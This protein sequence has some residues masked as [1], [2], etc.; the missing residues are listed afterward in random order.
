MGA[1]HAN[2]QQRQVTAH[3]QATCQRHLAKANA[4]LADCRLATAPRQPAM[5]RAEQIRPS[6]NV[7]R[8]AQRLL[9]N[10][11]CLVDHR[12]LLVGIFLF[13]RRGCSR[14]KGLGQACQARFILL[15]RKAA[16]RRQ[17]DQC[18][19]ALCKGHQQ[20]RS[21]A[22]ISTS[23]RSRATSTSTSTRTSSSRT[24]PVSICPGATA[25]GGPCTSFLAE[26]GLGQ[27][28]ARPCTRVER[29][30]NTG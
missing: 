24:H 23:D 22:D 5:I 18:S 4:K 1:A 12:C 7:V 15:E 11:I 25:A 21:A 2:S 13:E 17:A 14:G 30:H 16:A 10:V 28:A 8:A 6:H 27:T 20:Q 26:K 19:H 9:Q 3:C 29:T